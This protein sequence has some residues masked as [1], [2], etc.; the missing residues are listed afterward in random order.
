M[1]LTR[2][3]ALASLLAAPAGLRAAAEGEGWISL[4]DGKSLNGWQPSENTG[5]WKVV[6]GHLAA[7]GPRSHLFYAGPV[8]NAEFRNF[9]LS[10]EFMTRPLANSGV[11]F[12]TA[13]QQ[14]DWPSK[15]FEVQV[16]ATAEGEGTYRERKKGGSLYGIRNIYKTLAPDDQWHRMNIVVRG[17]QVQVSLNG[18]LLVDYLEPARPMVA[19][20]APGRVLSSGTFALQCHDPGSKAF[21]RNI[22]VKPLPDDASAV[23]SYEPLTDE[24]AREWFRL[25]AA[26]MPVVDYHVHLKSGWTLDQA[27]ANSRKVGIMYGLAVNC[28]VTFP[29]RNDAGVRDFIASVKNAPVFIAIQ[30][31][32]REWPGLVS[33]DTLAQV[34]YTFTDA[35]TFTDDRGKRMRLWINEEVGQIEDRQKFMDLYV[36]KIAGVIRDEPIDIYANPTFLPDVIASG[37]EELWTTE[38]MSKVIDAAK[39]HDVAIEINNRYRIPS[40]A[41]IKL[42]KQAGV[43]F[44]FGTNNS[45]ANIGRMEYCLEMVKACNLRWQE[46]FYPRLGDNRSKRM[47]T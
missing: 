42:A 5:S 23:V 32:G 29:V 26:N 38:R 22:R 3:N 2:R 39:K 45:D 11:Y 33:K 14:K 17:K 36:Q 37:Y 4:F 24:T 25:T 6:D 1:S 34:D 31:E 15:G 21:Y 30:G 28:G 41:F 20:D 27:L 40:E 43:K 18:V 35:M 13:F 44:S 46:I 10:L 9:E 19:A 7:D 47:R 8:K 12:H 16:N